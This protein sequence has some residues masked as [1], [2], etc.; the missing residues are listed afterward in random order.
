MKINSS[1]R[2]LTLLG[3]PEL[4]VAKGRSAKTQL[5]HQCSEQ[6]RIIQ[7][8]LKAKRLRVAKVKSCTSRFSGCLATNID[9]FMPT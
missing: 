9:P 2:Q 8:F 5:F 6:S 7:K 1:H 4:F 3:L